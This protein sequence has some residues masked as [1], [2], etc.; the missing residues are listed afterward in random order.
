[1]PAHILLYCRQRLGGALFS[2]VFFV[3]FCVAFCTADNAHARLVIKERPLDTTPAWGKHINLL[4]NAQ[5][6]QSVPPF[7]VPAYTGALYAT[8]PDLSPGD[9]PPEWL[10]R[11]SRASMRHGVDRSLLAAVLKAESNFNAYAVS[12]KGARGAMQIMPSTGKRM[13][14]ENFF[15]PEENLNAGA[16]YL[17][18][19]LKE[20]TALELALAAYNAGPEAV[21]KH[22]GIPPYEETRTY[23]TRVMDLFNRYKL[24]QPE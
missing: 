2:L 24:K 10:D 8:Q 7:A 6:E 20:F 17:A 16:G 1:M 9:V 19:L 12:P 5:P 11:I 14:L 13:G 21:R 15:D 18:L 3:A 22:G 4:K 23:V